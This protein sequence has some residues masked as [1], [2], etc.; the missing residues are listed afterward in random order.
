MADMPGPVNT[1]GTII[2]KVLRT[3]IDYGVKAVKAALVVQAPWLGLPVVSQITDYLLG[4]VGNYFYTFFAQHATLLVIEF[5]TAAEKT[6]YLSSLDVLQKAQLGGDANAIAQAKKD[7][8]AK[9]ASLIHFD[10]WVHP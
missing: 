10:G 5:D 9:L 4:I 3:A 7:A 6:A 2:N 1:V 8:E